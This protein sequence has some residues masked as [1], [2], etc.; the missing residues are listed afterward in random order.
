[1]SHC[2][3]LC[4]DVVIVVQ[5]G[6]LA[7]EADIANDGLESCFVHVWRTRGCVVS[8]TTGRGGT[9]DGMIGYAIAENALVDFEWDV[10]VVEVVGAVDVARP[11]LGRVRCLLRKAVHECVELVLAP[12]VVN[13]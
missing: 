9:Q 12:H 2:C 1:M 7:H 3:K 5:G 4:Q 13:W 10:M 11:N 8:H 6:C